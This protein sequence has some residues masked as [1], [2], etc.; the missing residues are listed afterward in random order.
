[1]DTFEARL[2]AFLGRV[3]IN[4][5][6]GVDEVNKPMIRHWVEAIGTS[7]GIHLDAQKALASG[8]KSIVAPAAMTQAWIMQGYVASLNPRQTEV[9]GFVELVSLLDEGGYTAVVATDSDFEFYRELVIGDKISISE[10]V[11]KISSEKNTALGRGRFIT[12]KKI[13]FDAKDQVVATQLW[14]TLRF[15]PV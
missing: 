15:I 14:R 5:R 1:M 13:Y 6:P 10:V 2:A 8:R 11:E 4:K 12:T 3:I 9:D 7:D